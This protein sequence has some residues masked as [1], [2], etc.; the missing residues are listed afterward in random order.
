MSWEIALSMQQ[1]SWQRRGWHETLNNNVREWLNMHLLEHAGAGA[2][3]KVIW[4]M[5][6]DRWVLP[7]H[8]RMLPK[9]QGNVPFW[10]QNRK[11]LISTLLVCLSKSNEVQNV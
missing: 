11:V 9:K 5:T 6:A 4:D 10:T 1:P 3:A 2:R 8:S 7:L